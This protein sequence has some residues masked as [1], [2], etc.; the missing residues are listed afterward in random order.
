MWS[1]SCEYA[2]LGI[3]EDYV[4]TNVPLQQRTKILNEGSPHES[5]SHRYEN[6]TAHSC[7]PP[8]QEQCTDSFPRYTRSSG[9][10]LQS[11]K[12]PTSVIFVLC[13]GLSRMPVSLLPAFDAFEV[14]TKARFEVWGSREVSDPIRTLGPRLTKSGRKVAMEA[15]MMPR[16]ISSLS[17]CEP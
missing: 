7:I 16:F 12:V 2:V 14:Q 5:A 13:I 17:L 3:V 8:T 10:S 9:A 15:A 1:F 6:E 11:C 4:V